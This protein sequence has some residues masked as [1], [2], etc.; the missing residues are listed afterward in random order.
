MSACRIFDILYFTNVFMRPCCKPHYMS[1]PVL[2]VRSSVSISLIQA[3]N[4]K[5]KKCRKAKFGVRIPQGTSKWNVNFQLKRSK[6][7]VTWCQNFKKVPPIW[8][9]CLPVETSAR[10]SG[11]D[12]KLGLGLNHFRP[13][14]MCG[15]WTAP[16]F[17]FTFQWCCWLGD[18]MWIPSSL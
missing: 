6:V 5:T 15:S 7:K 8:R 11:A 4:S 18:M 3:C 13:N 2:P 16:T 9:T 1:C 14:E 17:S 10:G 12:C